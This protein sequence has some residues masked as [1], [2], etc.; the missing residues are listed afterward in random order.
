MATM[1]WPLLVWLLWHARIFTYHL[2][3]RSWSNKLKNSIWVLY[4]P[5]IYA[6]PCWDVNRKYRMQKYVLPPY[7]VRLVISG[8]YREE[9]QI[10]INKL[11]LSATERER[12]REKMKLFLWIPNCGIEKVKQNNNMHNISLSPGSLK[13]IQLHTYNIQYRDV[14]LFLWEEY[15]NKWFWRTNLP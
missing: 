7:D 13:S 14:Y 15:R 8:R 9:M 2:I 4:A 1:P 12:E 11:N 5:Y 6:Y 10:Q 3:H